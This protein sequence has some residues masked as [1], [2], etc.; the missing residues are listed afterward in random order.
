MINNFELNPIDKIN[1]IENDAVKKI[2]SIAVTEAQKNI[3]QSR[4]IAV[5]RVFKEISHKLPSI[6][7]GE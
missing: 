1:N 3:H 4:N 6:V 7:Q 5:D 2:C